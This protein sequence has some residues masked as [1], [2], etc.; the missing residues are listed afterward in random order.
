MATATL[1]SVDRPG[2]GLA[3]LNLDKIKGVS[4]VTIRTPNWS[5]VHPLNSRMSSHLPGAQ[6]ETGVADLRLQIY[7]GE[8]DLARCKG[9]MALVVSTGNHT[10]LCW[11]ENRRCSGVEDRPAAAAAL[12]DIEGKHSSIDCTLPSQLARPRSFR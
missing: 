5:A 12:S 9:A 2:G 1:Y 11:I 8:T 4:Y 7:G 10:T 6:P 3:R